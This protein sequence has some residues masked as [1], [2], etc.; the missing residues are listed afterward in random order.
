MSS[1]RRSRRRLSRR[2]RLLAATSWTRKSSPHLLQTRKSLIE[3]SCH[4]TLVTRACPLLC[5]REPKNLDANR[6]NR[7]SS[8]RF[9][10]CGFF[11]F[12]LRRLPDVIGGIDILACHLP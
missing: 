12:H 9:T 3:K 11:H 10:H 2:P 7:Q 1:R 4:H 8:G 6:A 5:D